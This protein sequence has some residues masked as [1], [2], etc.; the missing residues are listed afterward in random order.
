MMKKVA[1]RSRSL[2]GLQQLKTLP[3]PGETVTLRALSSQ[4]SCHTHTHKRVQYLGPCPPRGSCWSL[5]QADVDCFWSKAAIAHGTSMRALP[6]GQGA[7]KTHTNTQTHKENVVHQM[8]R[9]HF[10]FV[11]LRK[12]LLTNIKSTLSFLVIRL[13][14]IQHTLK[15]LH[16]VMGKSIYFIK[17]SVTS[18]PDK[19]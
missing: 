13:K 9:Q 19:L 5:H 2:A 18:N 11:C 7:V 17:T 3:C 14:L 10:L 1:G 12:P 15:M 16:A 6:L 8:K 4:Q